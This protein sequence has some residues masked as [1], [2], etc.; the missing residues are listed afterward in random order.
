MWWI[1][2][3]K[4]LKKSAST[5][6]DLSL[7]RWCQTATWSEHGEMSVVSVYIVL[8]VSL[9]VALGTLDHWIIGTLPLRTLASTFKKQVVA[10]WNWLQCFSTLSECYLVTSPKESRGSIVYESLHPPSIDCVGCER[11]WEDC[12]R[13]WLYHWNTELLPQID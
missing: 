11:V 6:C 3:H 8:G 4:R 5:I 7:Y 1:T 9:A 12:G 2:W 10:P 13:G